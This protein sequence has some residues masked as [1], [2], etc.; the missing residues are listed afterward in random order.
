MSDGNWFHAYCIIRNYIIGVRIYNHVSKF[1]VGPSLVV[2]AACTLSS[3]FQLLLSVIT[4]VNSH[5]RDG[6]HSQ[7]HVHTFTSSPGS[8]SFSDA[9]LFSISLSTRNLVQSSVLVF[10]ESPC[11]RGPIY[12]SLSLSLNHKSHFFWRLVYVSPQFSRL[13]LV[14]FSIFSTRIITVSRL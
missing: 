9:P 13:I 8:V 6:S 2:H 11:L 10:E 1:R 4:D 14:S 3:Q 7:P 12:K 5:V